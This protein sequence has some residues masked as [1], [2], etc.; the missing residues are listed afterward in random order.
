MNLMTTLTEPTISRTDAWHSF[1]ELRKQST[2]LVTGNQ[3]QYHIRDFIVT[4]AQMISIMNK[5]CFL[6]L[7]VHNMFPP[8]NLTSYMIVKMPNS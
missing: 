8:F 7:L 5:V 1:E 4:P 2:N 6:C 3:R